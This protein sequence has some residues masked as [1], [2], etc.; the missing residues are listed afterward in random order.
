MTQII[1]AGEEAGNMATVDGNDH[2]EQLYVFY[3][4][5]ITNI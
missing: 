3:F 1:L 4:I 5:E 2:D